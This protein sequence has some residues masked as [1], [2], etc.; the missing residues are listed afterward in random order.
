MYSLKDSWLSNSISLWCY[1]LSLSQNFNQRRTSI[2][3]RSKTGHLLYHHNT[4]SPTPP[5]FVAVS[6]R[7]LLT[8]RRGSFLEPPALVLPNKCQEQTLLLLAYM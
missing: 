8:P 7:C 3:E 6:R 4:R 1:R 2:L 5:F